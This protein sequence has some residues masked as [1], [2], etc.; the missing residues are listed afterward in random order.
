LENPVK[1][2]PLPETD[3]ARIAPLPPKHKR[4][5]LEQLRIGRPPYRYAPVR[6]CFSDILNVHAALFGPLARTPFEKI[7]LTI[8]AESWS[9]DEELANLRVAEGLYNHAVAHD[10]HGRKQEFFPMAIGIGEKVVFWHSLILTI[11]GRPTVPFFDP[12]RQTK[13]LTAEA[14]RFVFS[15]M[16]QRIRVV[17]PDFAEVSLGIYQFATPDK[18]PRAPVLHTDDGLVLFT[19]DELEE[20]VRDTYAIWN[21]V[22]AARTEERRSRSSGGGGMF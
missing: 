18:G 19:F 9:D 1:I 7:A 22:C 10:L 17:D 21:E 2:P 8:R 3:L 6:K 16:H 20:M 14:R 11:G 15:M 5:A 12:R 4:R 13:R